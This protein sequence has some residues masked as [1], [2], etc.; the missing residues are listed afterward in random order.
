MIDWQP[1]ITFGHFVRRCIIGM[2]L[3]DVEILAAMIYFVKMI[4]DEKCCF[5][6]KYP[7]K[8]FG[9]CAF[10]AQKVHSDFAISNATY[11]QGIENSLEE[12][13]DQEI[14]LLFGI[15]FEVY[16]AKCEIAM[17][18][19]TFNLTRITIEPQII[20]YGLCCSG[21]CRVCLRAV[22]KVVTRCENSRQK[23]PK[24]A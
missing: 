9:M 7:H 16:T 17:I 2:K 21:V 19:K 3:S 14:K 1:V 11:A 15:N 4:V 5:L 10:L 18:T 24:K 22:D 6:L 12:I 20:T 8:L 23:N 13:N